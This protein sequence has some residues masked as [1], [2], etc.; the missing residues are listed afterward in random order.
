MDLSPFVGKRQYLITYAQANIV[1][2]PTRKSFCEALEE[3]FNSESRKLKVIAVR[4]PNR[5]M[6]VGA[7]TTTAHWSQKV[8]KY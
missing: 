8:D 7:F 4:L 6:K 3:E 5:F 1:N 2:F